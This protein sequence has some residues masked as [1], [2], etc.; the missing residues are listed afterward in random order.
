MRRRSFLTLPPLAATAAVA[1][2][3]NE[4]PKYRVQSAY[5][6][7]ANPGMPG[8][9]RG[10]VASV[11]APKS[12]DVPTETVDVPTVQEMMSRGMLS[13]TG[14]KDL[15]TAWRRFV[16]PNDVVG[17]KVN[18]SGAPGICSHPVIVA[19]TV[20]QLIATGVKP[21]NIWIYERFKD[22]MDSVGYHKYVPE[23][24][25][26]LAASALR[27]ALN[28]YDPKTYVEV[29][30]FGEEDTRSN[31]IRQVSE[32][33]TKI[34]NIPNMKDHGASGV[35]GCLKNIA[36]GNF[37]NVAR[38]HRFEKTNTFSF[39]GALAMVEPVRSRT[40]LHLMD[41]LKGVWHGGPF[42]PTKDYRFYPAKMMFGTDPVAM[43]R[44][45]LDIIEDQRKLKGAVS[46]WNRSPEHLIKTGERKSGPNW[47]R[48]IREPGHIE[49]AATLGL[50]EYDK[51]KIDFRTT[52]L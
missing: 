5:K 18:C 43:D 50:G 52:T 48:F 15:R 33:F 4:L 47:N 42:S 19:E 45:L 14:D 27:D 41:G 30:F 2:T 37:H 21:S 1:A 26:I 22:Q 51:K 17:L 31:V 44:I 16:E 7:W 32:N 9:F 6:P 23:G 34:I 25:N 8:A 3:P 46:V 13:L 11:H 28:G 10:R 20:R 35:T 36:Y 49:Y 38:S 40:V 39:I 24:V 29:D 12:I